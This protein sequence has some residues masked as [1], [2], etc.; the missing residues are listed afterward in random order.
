VTEQ[1]MGSKVSSAAGGDEPVSAPA[2]PHSLCTPTPRG[3]PSNYAP[4]LTPSTH[5]GENTLIRSA[6]PSPALSLFAVVSP[7]EVIK[8]DQ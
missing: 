5:A 3:D 4:P 8:R 2:L 7:L 1:L 6:P